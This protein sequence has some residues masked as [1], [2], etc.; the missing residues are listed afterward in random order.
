MIGSIGEI[1]MFAGNYAPK[2]WRLCNGQLLNP[3]D[4]GTLF[5]IISN[6]YGGDGR[7][8]FALPDM[9]GRV[10]MDDGQGKGLT[11]R[12]IGERFGS[13]DITLTTEQI[14]LHKHSA[15]GTVNVYSSAGDVRL[16][17]K[18]NL[19]GSSI[20]NQ[21]TDQENNTSMVDGS[22]YMTVGDTGKNDAMPILGPTSVVNFIICVFGLLDQESEK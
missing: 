5:A 16:P 18:N 9:R 19:A 3:Q 4:Y 8:T 10:P 17:T 2:N 15:T 1:R 14:P 13:E 20:D 7:T 21:Y 22:V 11:K 12:I 6:Y